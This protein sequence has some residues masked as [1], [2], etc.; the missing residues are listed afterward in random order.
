MSEH[1][2]EQQPQKPRFWD[3]VVSVLAALFGVQSD[4]NRQRD[5]NHGNPAVYVAI[6]AVFV[7]LFVLTLVLVVNWVVPG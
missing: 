5:F 7:I 1:K 3:I 2:P 6:G 4:K